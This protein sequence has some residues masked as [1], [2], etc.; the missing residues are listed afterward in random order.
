M[1]YRHTARF[2]P[3]GETPRSASETRTVDVITPEAIPDADTVSQANTRFSNTI[4]AYAARNHWEIHDVL[5]VSADR[6]WIP[7]ASLRRELKSE[8]DWIDRITTVSKGREKYM[9]IYHSENRS[10]KHLQQRLQS[11]CDGQSTGVFISPD[12]SSKTRLYIRWET[13][14]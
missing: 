2:V 13:A 14:L 12:T 3:K 11:L 7:A 1:D 9:I 4:A 10:C 8:C 6:Q 5:T